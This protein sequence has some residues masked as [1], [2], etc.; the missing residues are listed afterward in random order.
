MR[1]HPGQV[2]LLM[3]LLACSGPHRSRIQYGVTTA[4]QLQAEKGSPVAVERPT[5][6]ARLLVYPE[7]QKFQV[8]QDVVVAGFRVP[9]PEE[10]SLL[11]WRHKFQD[12]ETSFTRAQAE[13][14]MQLKCQAQ[15]MTVLYNSQADLV[16]R[17]VEHATN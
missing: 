6:E 10:R 7:D 11:Y 4:A 15:G 16:V 17:V 9:R 14:E 2:C 1:S 5:T 13:G 3:F 12:C 8:Q